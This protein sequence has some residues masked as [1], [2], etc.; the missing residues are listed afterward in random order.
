MLNYENPAQALSSIC[1]EYGDSIIWGTDDPYGIYVS[2]TL[3]DEKSVLDA[4]DKKTA[5]MIGEKNT[6]RYLYGHL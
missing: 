1:E 6:K 2:K 5:K 4:I 3:R